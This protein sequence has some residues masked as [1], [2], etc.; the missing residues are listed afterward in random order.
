MSKILNQINYAKIERDVGSI[1]TR[2]SKNL[3]AAYIRQVLITNWEVGKCLKDSLPVSDAPSADNARVIAKLSRKFKRPDSYFYMLIK[4]A[5][6]Y[7]KLP[8]NG[9]GSLSWSHY[10]A[11]LRIDD[12]AARQRYERMAVSKNI[13]GNLLYGLIAADRAKQSSVILSEAKNLNVVRGR[14]YHYKVTAPKSAQCNIGTAT[15]DVGFKIFR[16]IPLS[17][18]SKLHVGHM[19]HTVK[20]ERT[21]PH[22]HFEAKQPV[23]ILRDATSKSKSRTKDLNNLDSAPSGLRMTKSF[24]Q[25][26]AKIANPDADWLYTYVAQVER[27]VDG[28]TL[29]AMIDLGLKTKIRQKLRLRGIDTPELTAKRGKYVKDHVK[30]LLDKQKFIIVKTYK[31]DKYGRM[32]AD[33]FYGPAKTP[34]VKLINGLKTPG[35]RSLDPAAVAAEGIFLNQYLLDKGLAKIWRA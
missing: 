28:D 21:A 33:I 12:P 26:T 22:R 23:V 14:L 5:R 29:I 24:P 17:R 1:I 9:N 16:D 13:S 18:K 8:G 30:K 20:T 25:F 6:L 15:L 3:R 19:V 35:V 27:V 7:P 4:F 32:L 2:G 11:L 34:V 31:D 10:E